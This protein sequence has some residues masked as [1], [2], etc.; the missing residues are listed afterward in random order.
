MTPLTETRMHVAA[1]ELAEREPLFAAVIARFGLPPMWDRPQ[2]FGS[3]IHIMLEQQVS[4]AS[5]RAAFDRLTAAAGPPAA[6]T[7]LR[8]DDGQ[9]LQIG[10]SRQKTRYARALAAAIGDGSLALDR[11]AELD[12]DAVD[13]ALR[14]VPGIGPWTAS[15]YRLSALGRP[16]AWPAGDLALAVAIAD[17]WHLPAPPAPPETIRRAEAWRPWRAVATRLLWQH[18]LGTRRTARPLPL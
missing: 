10:F 14:A 9:L 17:L 7:F 16:D 4:L 18:Y 8:L 5:A 6:E 12:D 11:L 3:L 1:Q 2:G 13:R 15:I